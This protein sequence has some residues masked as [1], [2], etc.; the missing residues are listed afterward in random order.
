MII[1][2]SIS[3]LILIYLYQK[4]YFSHLISK[5]KFKWL[6]RI[7]NV[8]NSGGVKLFPEQIEKKLDH[9]IEGR[10]FIASEEDAKLGN[11]VI[12]ILE[13]NPI[14]L[15]KKKFEVL[16]KYERPKSIYFISKFSETK[17]GKINRNE[18]LKKVRTAR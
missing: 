18:T 8:I 9:L 13:G 14:D 16:S 5:N 1:F 12:L 6:G 2:H 7:D 15:D 4:L 10:F 17:T 3:L 11:K